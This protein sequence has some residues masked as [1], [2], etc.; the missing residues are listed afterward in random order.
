MRDSA[1][2][3]RPPRPRAPAH[4]HAGADPL[5]GVRQ[6]AVDSL[7]G[8]R[9]QAGAAQDRLRV[10]A[11]QRRAA[12]RRAAG[13][14]R[15][16]ALP[17]ACR[18]WRD[19]GGPARRLRCREGGRLKRAQRTTALSSRAARRPRTTTARP[20]SRAPSSTWRRTLWA[21]TTCRC[22][23]RWDSSARVI[24]RARAAPSVREGSRSLAGAGRQG[25][26]LSALHL[27]AAAALDAPDLPRG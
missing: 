4:P 10:P 17:T 15:P 25:R 7:C 16:P 22:S 21:P 27:H 12:P 23:R 14:H 9:A 26:R 24:R 11:T 2:L 3:P 13:A 6:R 19:Q 5:L 8:G 20:L 18:R 1:G